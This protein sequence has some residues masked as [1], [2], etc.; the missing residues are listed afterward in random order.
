MSTTSFEN[1]SLIFSLA[2][3]CIPNL[4]AKILL[5]Y[6]SKNRDENLMTKW[7]W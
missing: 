4:L 7:G 6:L 3:K 5:Y 2:N 1:L